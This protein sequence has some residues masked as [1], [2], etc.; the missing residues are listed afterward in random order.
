MRRR[1]T[2]AVLAGALL[3]FSCTRAT[4]KKYQPD[5]TQSL[6]LQL[7]HKDGEMAQIQFNLAQQNLNKA[8]NDITAE[9][10][11]IKKENGWPVELI[12]DPNTLTFKMP[13]APTP[14]PQK[15]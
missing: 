3:F 7:K 12:L 14:E 6:R 15:K 13:P 5:P 10:E 9:G 1:F 11:A 2:L 4:D 8:L